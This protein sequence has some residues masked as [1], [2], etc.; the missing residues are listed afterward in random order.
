MAIGSTKSENFKQ[1]IYTS[2]EEIETYHLTKQL[3]RFFISLDVILK[4]IVL[5][6]FHQIEICWVQLFSYLVRKCDHLQY[7]VEDLSQIY[8]FGK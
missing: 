7:W 1:K 4:D 6:T 8:N 5:N 3:L 2:V